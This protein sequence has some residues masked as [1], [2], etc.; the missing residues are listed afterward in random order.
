MDNSIAY[1]QTGSAKPDEKDSAA[2]FV[3]NDG[4]TYNF[5]V[6]ARAVTLNSN[7]SLEDVLSSV[8]HYDT[9]ITDEEKRREAAKNMGFV[10]VTKPKKE[11]VKD[12]E[13]KE[14]IDEKGEYVTKD[15]PIYEES[16]KEQACKNINAVYIYGSYSP[17]EKESIRL[18]IGAVGS[19]EAAGGVNLDEYVKNEDY[20]PWKNSVDGSIDNI[21]GTIGTINE[22]IEGLKDADYYNKDKEITIKNQVTEITEK[23]SNHI[24]SNI[25]TASPHGISKTLIQ[26]MINNSS[27]PISGGTF[28]GNVK[29]AA[30]ESNDALLRNIMIVEADTDVTKLTDI[31]KGT[32]I[33]QKK[34]VKT[35]E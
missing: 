1:I 12:A 17:E 15:I 6:P 11:I 18:A 16:E 20:S 8:I 14:V 34:A 7:S 4:M 29:A 3:D 26:S 23:S 21:N 19:K 24:D 30:T 9:K 28:S 2:Y 33:F 22:D 27:M 5:V 35:A 25:N 10:T 13:G 32:L 31:P